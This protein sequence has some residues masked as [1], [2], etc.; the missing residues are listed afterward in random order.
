ML[1]CGFFFLTGRLK[2]TPE[3]CSGIRIKAETQG[4]SSLVVSYTHDHIHLSASITIAAYLPIK[5]SL[6]LIKL[7]F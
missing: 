4:Y 1:S 5:V 6:S 3:Y 2:P 7:P